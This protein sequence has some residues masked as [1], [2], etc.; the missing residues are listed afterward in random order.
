MLKLNLKTVFIEGGIILKL[1]SVHFTQNCNLNCPFCY[2][3][4]DP[5]RSPSIS[6]SPLGSNSPGSPFLRTPDFDFFLQFP[7]IAASLQIPQIALGGGEPTLYPEF[8]LKFGELCHK[9]NVIVNLT[10]NGY[11]ISPP[12]LN[13]LRYFTLVS[14]S[15]DTFKV[16]NKVQFS[17]LLRK[18][19]MVKDIGC[20][21]GANI[22]LDESTTTNLIPIALTLQHYADF[23]YFLQMKPSTLIDYQKLKTDLLTLKTLIG[24]VWIDDSLKLSFH[25]TIHCGRGRDI[26]SINPSKQAS[27]CSFDVPFANLSHP[28]DLSSILQNLYPQEPTFSCPFLAPKIPQLR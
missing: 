11:D 5:Q 20:K 17:D 15:F 27:Y 26:L 7:Q 14:F 10:T 22:L 24:R 1:L 21:I 19:V 8:L 2:V 25:Q 9:H 12:I 18:M 4:K 23:L 13:A 3:H 6:N 16:Q 28:S